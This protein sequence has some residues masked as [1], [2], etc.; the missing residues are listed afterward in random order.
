MTHNFVVGREY[1]QP[2]EEADIQSLKRREKIASIL[3][4]L[5]LTQQDR[6]TA[7][8]RLRLVPA[9]H[10]GL[11]AAGNLFCLA[12]LI[13]IW[14]RKKYPVRLWEG[15]LIGIFGPPALAALYIEKG[16]VPR[17]LLTFGG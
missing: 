7:Y 16:P 9:K 13:I 11:A 17:R 2:L 1:Y 6:T 3:F 10:L 14:R 15:L 8:A 4:P 5:R 12:L